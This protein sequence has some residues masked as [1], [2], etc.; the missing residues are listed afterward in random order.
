MAP[1]VVSR[2][3]GNLG[4]ASGVGAI[5]GVALVAMIW[6]HEC[7]RRM[8]SKVWCGIANESRAGS[9]DRVHIKQCDRGEPYPGKLD[10]IRLIVPN[11]MQERGI[12]IRG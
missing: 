9:R 11:I 5:L 7:S 10:P 3:W 6:P 12:W 4:G 2:R 1:G 8:H